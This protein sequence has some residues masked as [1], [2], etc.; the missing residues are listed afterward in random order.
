MIFSRNFVCRN[1]RWLLV[2]HFLRNMAP[3]RNFMHIW[4]SSNSKGLENNRSWRWFYKYVERKLLLLDCSVCNIFL[5][6]KVE[7]LSLSVDVDNV[8]W[9]IG[10]VVFC[11]SLI[12]LSFY[13]NSLCGYTSLS[14]RICD[15]W[16]I[17]TSSYVDMFLKFFIP[18]YFLRKALIEQKGLRSPFFSQQEILILTWYRILNTFKLF[19][20]H[21]KKKIAI[22]L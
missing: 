3:T 8:G 13:L 2:C 22:N 10:R 14:L 19:S 1:T 18:I 15:T 17:S 6:I 12:F 11:F 9:N 16:L 7:I 21:L 20:S 5:F 4:N